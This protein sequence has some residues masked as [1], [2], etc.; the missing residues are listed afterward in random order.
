LALYHLL[1]WQQTCWIAGI[2]ARVLLLLA[3]HPFSCPSP[4]QR[5]LT[6]WEGGFRA[7]LYTAACTTV[8][9]H[10]DL[11]RQFISSKFCCYIAV[12]TWRFSA[13]DGA[14]FRTMT[15]ADSTGQLNSNERKQGGAIT[16]TLRRR[17]PSCTTRWYVR[18]GIAPETA[19]SSNLFGIFQISA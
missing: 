16:T 19:L 11:L 17:L 12:N 4:F 1:S 13:G 10:I 5:S 9:S 7:T 2:C 15:I 6:L 3:A 14:L 18:C 8:R